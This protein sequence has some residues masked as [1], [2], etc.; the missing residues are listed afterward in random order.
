[1]FIFRLWLRIWSMV[2]RVMPQWRVTKSTPSSAWSRTT[3]IKSRAVRVS[4]SRW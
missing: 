2:S 1:M 4:R 3:S